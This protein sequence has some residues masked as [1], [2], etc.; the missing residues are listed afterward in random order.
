M[1][2]ESALSQPGMQQQQPAH[3]HLPPCYGQCTLLAAS[4]KSPPRQTLQDVC[5]T[6]PLYQCM[7]LWRACWQ[8]SSV[9]CVIL[10][11]I[12]VVNVCGMQWWQQLC[13]RPL[14]WPLLPQQCG[15]GASSLPQYSA[16]S[17]LTPPCTMPH[18]PNYYY[19]GKL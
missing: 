11:Y 15:S 4:A 14:H 19:V 12:Y 9:V 5:C 18:S 16:S 7:F 6:L 17:A 13:I 3:K 10:R 8:H 1:I 2:H